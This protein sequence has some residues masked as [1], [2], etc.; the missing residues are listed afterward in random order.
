VNYKNGRD[1]LPPSLLIELQKYIQG[2]LVYIP[3]PTDQRANWGEVS[4]TRKLL[5][6]RNA[7]IC[8]YYSN[9]WTV[10]DLEHKYHLSSES[11]RK[12]IVK[13]R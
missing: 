11:I 3:K 10:A 13:T 5:A 12:I 4:G 8:L 7:E 1:V 2:D 9:G 6:D